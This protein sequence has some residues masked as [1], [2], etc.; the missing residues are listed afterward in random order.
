MVPD[1]SLTATP[2]RLL[3]RSSPSALT[4]PGRP[5]RPRRRRV[6]PRRPRWRCARP[7]RCP[8]GPCRRPWRRRPCRPRRRRPPWLRRA[9]ATAASMPAP[10]RTAATRLTPPA[11]GAP[12]ST[13]MS[14]P[15]WLRTASA[16]SRRSAVASPSTRC[17][18]GAVDRCRR[19]L[20][21]PA[22][23]QLGPQH[24][25]LVA[26]RAQLV[27]LA[28]DAADEVVG[29]GADQP[30]GLGRSPARRAAAGPRWPSP[31]TA[32]MRRRLEPIEPSLT[33]LIVPM[34]PV[35]RTCVPPHSSIELPASSTRTMS[36]YLSPK[37]AIAPSASASDLRRL[38]GPH[39]GVGERLGVGQPLDLLDL[40]GGHRARSARSRSAGGRGRRASRPA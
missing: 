25:D 35:A 13:T 20:A 17:D 38:E 34:S 26:E 5:R 16:S 6:P 28:L 31:V 30:G 2:M 32:S 14:T 1:R 22:G 33:T 24:L 18:D 4:S 15:G 7:R 9:A 21:G 37:K 8:T 36:P 27:E 12:A 10:G 39:A 11:A 3:P 29:G 40:L 23:R 19:Q